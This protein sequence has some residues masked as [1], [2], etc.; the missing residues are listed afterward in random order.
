MPLVDS[1]DPH[2]AALASFHCSVGPRSAQLF[3]WLTLPCLSRLRAWYQHDFLTRQRMNEMTARV[4]TACQ[5]LPWAPDYTQE[6]PFTENSEQPPLNKLDRREA[7]V[8]WGRTVDLDQNLDLHTAVNFPA[9][10]WNTQ[11]GS[12]ASM[13]LSPRPRG[14]DS[15]LNADPAPSPSVFPSILHSLLSHLR[16]EDRA[17][18]HRALVGGPDLLTPQVG[19]PKDT[20]GINT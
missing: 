5:L 7:K 14:T 18:G 11:R 19:T 8:R 9:S 13:Y 3:L 20:Y 15:L 1:R 6:C 4:T 10:D 16:Q 12:L 17:Q 2:G